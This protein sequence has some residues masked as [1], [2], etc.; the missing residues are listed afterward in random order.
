M[1]EAMQGGTTMVACENSMERFKLKREVMLDKVSYVDAG[2][3]HIIERQHQGW[4]AI[5]P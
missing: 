5:R 4:S 1:R 3:V 2:V